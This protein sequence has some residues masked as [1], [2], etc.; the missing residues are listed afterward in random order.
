MAAKKNVSQ[1]PPGLKYPGVPE[2]KKRKRKDLDVVGGLSGKNIPFVVSVVGV[3]TLLNKYKGEVT[4]FNK[5]GVDA[6]KATT[7]MER[8]AQAVQRLERLHRIRL[9]E[10]TF[11]SG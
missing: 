1:R 4:A 8:E 5:C 2:K 10:D 7:D 11:A 6:D 3:T 9:I